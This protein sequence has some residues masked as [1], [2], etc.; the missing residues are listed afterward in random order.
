MKPQNV[1]HNT[2]YIHVEAFHSERLNTLAS[3]YRT[4]KYVKPVY[5]SYITTMF[6]RTNYQFEYSTSV[7]L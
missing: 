2:Y 6:Y 3:H 1:L 4:I 7:N 5:F